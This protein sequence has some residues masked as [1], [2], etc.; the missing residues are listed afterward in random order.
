MSISSSMY[1]GMSSLFCLGKKMAMLG[2]NIA[3]ISTT[4]FRGSQVS[5]EDVLLEATNTGGVKI[6]P[7]GLTSDF[8]KEG[9][10]EFS[11]TATNMAISG[12]GFFILRD[13]DD[14]STT[15]YTRAGE[16]SFDA[17]GYLVNPAGHVVQ[18]Y[19]FDNQGMETTTLTDIQLE[20]TTPAATVDN[21]DPAPRL[22]SSPSPST[23][24]TVTCNVDTRSQDNSPGGL[25]A[26]WDATNAEPISLNDYELRAGHDIYDSS[27]D[28]HLIE[29]YYDRDIG[30]GDN[31]W[32]YL[33]TASPDGTGSAS[34]EGVLARGNIT[35]DS[36][37]YINAMTIENYQG[38]GWTA[39]TINNNGYLTFQ[40]SFAGAG[41]VELDVGATYVNGL[42]QR[43]T[44]TTT[45]FGYGS[46]TKFSNTD[47]YGE[48]DLTDFSITSDGIIRARFD[49]SVISDLFR[50]VLANSID[51][52][53]RFQRIGSTLYQADS[54]NEDLI[55]GIPGSSGLGTIIGDSLETSNVDL[56]EQFGELIF[57][58]RA[59]QANAKGIVAAD[60][61]IKTA[62]GLKR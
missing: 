49:N 24:L 23:R 29:V 47:G 40:T 7:M 22:V 51:P 27:G 41:T 21:P 42:W 2:D 12:D 55:T 62:M 59:L 28:K 32:E 36:Y 44:Q 19:G 46:Y 58:Q 33:V 9:S 43:D 25:F 53:S 26:K 18:G 17:D 60:E 38:G 35:F 5:F 30:Q 45:Q 10:T 6:S 56:V 34:D 31:V 4:G 39:G 16:F 15:Y 14:T 20:L 11:H 1:M 13:K 54:E 52:S 48:G 57:T 3:N 8:S 50:V 37:G 61:M